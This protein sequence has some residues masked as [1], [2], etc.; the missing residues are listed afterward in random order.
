MLA[1]TA[2]ATRLLAA[3]SRV[4]AARGAPSPARLR[5]IQRP[6]VTHAAR[7]ADDLARFDRLVPA[8]LRAG[9]ATWDAVRA[10]VANQ[11]DRLAAIDALLRRHGHRGPGERTLAGARWS[12]GPAVLGELDAIVA[13]SMPMP[14]AVAEAHV[15]WWRL[16][17][18]DP[19]EWW[20]DG[21]VA[22]G[23]FAMA[24]RVRCRDRATRASASLRAALLAEGEALVAAGKLER[25]DDVFH[26]RLN[27]WLAAAEGSGELRVR[28]R[29]RRAELDAARR[30][31]A[32]AIVTDA[33]G[34]A[35]PS[36]RAQ[37]R[38]ACAAQATLF[39]IAAS[40]GSMRGRVFHAG[41][42][43][44]A[45]D[46]RD[47]HVVLVLDDANPHHA[48]LL[49]RASALVCE[50]GGLLSHL[51]IVARELGVPAVMGVAGATAALAVGTW[52]EVDGSRGVVRPLTARA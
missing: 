2:C 33:A 11:P 26:L 46:P 1:W 41:D 21:L 15:P 39:G 10:R 13:A 36:M 42:T 35:P 43:L 51:A 45:A 47:A 6:E 25:A 9:V 18:L 30:S 40:A 29:E 34:G 22:L 3:S 16:A 8:S 12:D 4:A 48:A 52:V 38:L 23:A 24:R 28:V 17:W 20:L 14:A 27:E 31:R 5:R 44:T 7:L 32:P 19:L 37:A 49:A 50:R